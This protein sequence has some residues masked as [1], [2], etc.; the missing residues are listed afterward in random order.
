MDDKDDLI[1]KTIHGSYLI[2][3]LIGEGGMGRV[4]LAENVEVREKKYAIKVLKRELTAN[5]KFMN[6]FFEEATHQAQLDHS[7]IVQMENYFKEG[8]DYFLVLSFVEGRSLAEIIDSLHGP[9]PKKQAA[10]IFKEVLR[11]LNCA[12]EKAI[13]HRDIKASNVMVDNSGRALLTDFGIARQAGDEQ[14]ASLGQVIGTP[15]YM[16]PEQ[17]IDSDKVD[18]RSDVYSAGILLFEML[19]GQLPFK[20]S[21][22]EL[23]EKHL[24]AP[25]PNPRTINPKIKKCLAEAVVKATQKEPDARFQGCIAFLKAV[26]RCER[27]RRWEIAALGLSVVI[28]A[29]AWYMTQAEN[30]K[31]ARTLAASSV[32]NYASLCRE[33]EALERK[34]LGLRTAQGIGDS[35]MAE[36]FQKEINAH[37]I[38][39]SK[40]FGEYSNA[41][42]ELSKYQGGMVHKV[43]K[44][45]VHEE[46]ANR[47]PDPGR[48]AERERFER[49]TGENF[50]QRSS[51]G[52]GPTVETMLHNCP[53]NS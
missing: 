35:G 15:E 9:M 21:Q 48:Q 37:K 12:H 2:I 32:S 46:E 13:L 51:T 39:I 10:Q 53:R 11:A 16:S 34:E 17:F 27:G 42:D 38:K 33:A 47:T 36:A 18:H 29:G 3:S 43:L 49:L 40:F 22:D 1:G 14:A 28:A 31:A 30:E 23:R 25:V 4:Y 5:P 7:N 50:D 44:E 19:T 24:S 41:L 26:E 45:S 8:E 20:G 6:Q 52:K